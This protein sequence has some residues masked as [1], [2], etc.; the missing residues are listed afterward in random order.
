M[1]LFY[2]LT[3]WFGIGLVAAGIILT[4][5]GI[6][7][8]NNI[9]D[10]ISRGAISFVVAV[11]PGFIIMGTSPSYKITD[12]R[13]LQ[14]V[15]E[16]FPEETLTERD[17]YYILNTFKAG[18]KISRV[19][20]IVASS[21][22]EQKEKEKTAAKNEEKTNSKTEDISSAKNQKSEGQEVNYCPNCGTVKR[23]SQKSNQF[24]RL[25]YFYF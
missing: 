23:F 7:S 13:Y 11:F 19:K 6:C 15:R 25:L 4:I 18:E 17:G 2:G 20:S 12:D 10:K 9:E 24:F 3:F 5:V 1:T 21:D 22:I 16:V 14:A 8:G